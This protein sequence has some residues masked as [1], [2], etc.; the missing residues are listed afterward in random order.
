MLKDKVIIVGITGGIAAYKSVE[1]IRK[2]IKA[3]AQVHCV[4]TK[5]AQE[6]VTP[7]TFRTLTNNPVITDMFTEPKNWNVEHVALAQ[8]ADLVLI[9]P[10]TA[11]IIGKISYGIAD[12]FLT[13]LVMATKA[14]VLLAPAMNVN[15]Y[16]NPIT[17]EN[18]QRLTRFGYTFVE[19]EC[20]FLACGY[21]GKGRLAELD[22]IMEKAEELSEKDKP[23][24]GQRILITAGPT[25][26]YL[27]P[28]RYL[29]NHSSGK[30]G[31]ALAKQ[32]RLLGAEVVLISGPTELKPFSGVECIRVE[33]AREM[34]KA[35]MQNYQDFH[36]IIKAA[37]VADYRPR[38]Q[39]QEKI[40]KDNTKL[41]L[42]LEK[43]PDILAELGAKKGSRIVIG[44]AAETNDVLNYAR[45]KAQSKN[46]DFIVANNVTE[47]GAGFNFDTN[48]VSFVFPDQKVEKLPLLSKDEVAREILNQAI[49]INNSR[50]EI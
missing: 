21:E 35:V 25:R 20:G 12:D 18:I 11:N 1:L 14:P 24:L 43:N 47:P 46:L 40:K 9:V 36:I 16:E 2:L 6:F 13:T 49:K 15:M 26:E 22:K 5:S 50:S 44:F 32:A 38:V 31:Y 4:M 27:D 3:D 42:E 45:Q 7:L 30:M 33:T 19:P 41:C 37:A 34:Y 10:A 29:T 17:Q 48:I 8:R 23:L 39:Q 28:V